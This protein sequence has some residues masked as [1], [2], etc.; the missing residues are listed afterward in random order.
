MW[1]VFYLPRGRGDHEFG[2]VSVCSVRVCICT[3]LTLHTT[4][5]IRFVFL[6]HIYDCVLYDLSR[7]R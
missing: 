5:P 6:V 7:L 1:S 2:C 3:F 4:R